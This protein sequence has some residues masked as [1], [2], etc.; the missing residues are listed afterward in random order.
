MT[1]SAKHLIATLS[2]L[3]PE[4]H[5]ELAYLLIDS[6]DASENTDLGEGNLTEELDRRAKANRDGSSVGIPAHKVSEYLRRK[7]S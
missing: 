6:L 4:D 7:H 5:A 3:P 1:D 2:S